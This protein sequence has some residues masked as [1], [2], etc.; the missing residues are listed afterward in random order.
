[1]SGAVEAVAR[2]HP[3]AV[4]RLVHVGLFLGVLA[5]AGLVCELLGV[6][7]SGWLESLF[8]RIAEVSPGWIVLGLGLQTFQTFVISLAWVAILRFAYGR[9]AVAVLPV[10]AAYAVAVAL[11]GLLPAS[12]G[13]IV[14]L[15]MLL[16]VIPGSTFPG[17][18]S[19]FLV[20]QLFFFVIGAGLYLYLFISVEGTFSAKLGRIADHPWFTTLIVVGAVVVG[21][22]ILWFGWRKLEHLWEQAKQGGA[23]LSSPRRYLVGVVVPELAGFV[24][25]L[26]VI[27]VFM[28]AYGIPVSLHGVLFVGGSNSVSGVASFTPGGIGVNQT[29]NVA[30]LHG[31]ASAKEATAYSIGHQ[32]LTTGWNVLL[33][34]GLVAAVFGLTGGWRLIER[35]YEEAKE[36]AGELRAEKE[37]A[38]A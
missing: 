7:L 26:A 38:G 2:R 32:L 25:K 9:E 22:L 11:N 34:V 15:M 30:A 28:A 36:K 16:A 1:M 3:S 14:M 21:A 29:L 10:F 12:L 18:F 35:S 19:G 6:D 24:A 37:A 8:D 27:G 4:R 33:A 17:L 31:E 20:H 13:T 23:I 5:A